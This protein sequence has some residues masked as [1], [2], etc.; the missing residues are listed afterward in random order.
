M[1]WEGGAVTMCR[2][3]NKKLVA[4]GKGE[5]AC[6]EAALRLELCGHAEEFAFGRGKQG[7]YASAFKT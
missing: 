3:S 2:V 6:H 1:F 5:F 4:V 7:V